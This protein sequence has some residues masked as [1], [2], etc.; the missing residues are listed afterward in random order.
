MVVNWQD[1]QRLGG[2]NLMHCIA[3]LTLVT[4]GLAFLM[5]G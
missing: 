5:E 4:P 1:C 2:E 3:T